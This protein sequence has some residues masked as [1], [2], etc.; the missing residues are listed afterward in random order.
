MTQGR[1]SFLRQS[2]YMYLTKWLRL[3][4]GSKFQRL[5]GESNL[6]TRQKWGSEK[7]LWS[8]H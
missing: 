8:S 1:D 6:M 7:L 4:T 3:P 5:G 2:V